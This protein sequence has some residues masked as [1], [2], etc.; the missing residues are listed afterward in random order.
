MAI[1]RLKEIL[2][3]SDIVLTLGAGNVWQVGENLLK[4]L[5]QNG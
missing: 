4:T 1:S 5:S 2:K 3:E